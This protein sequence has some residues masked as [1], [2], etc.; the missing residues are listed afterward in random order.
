[1]GPD[2]FTM[3][4]FSLKRMMGVSAYFLISPAKNLDEQTPVPLSEQTTIAMPED[5]QV[6]MQT[7]QTLA[8]Q[9]IS[10]LMGV[11]D[12]IARL[13]VERNGRFAM[14]ISLDNGGKQAVFLFKGDVYEGMDAYHLSSESLQYL[15]QHLGILSGL[16][17]LLRPFDLIQPYRLEMG[18]AL[19]NPQC[20]NLYQFWGSK[21]T[22]LLNQRLEDGGVEYLVNLASQEYFKS[23]QT[24]DINVPIITPVF[25]DEKNGQ[26]KIISFYAKRARGLMVKFAAENKITAVEELKQFN[27]EGYVFSE[28]DSTSNTWIF[29][30][31]ELKK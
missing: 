4:P 5:T 15:Q 27:L 17:G 31:P 11:S 29:K 7:L 6:L 28:T 26:Y 3:F 9:D 1:M 18:T 25:Q 19:K 23:V 14:P 20:D 16:Y 12:K 24:K 30:R 13:N 10:A 22:Q 21:I 2:L 8:P